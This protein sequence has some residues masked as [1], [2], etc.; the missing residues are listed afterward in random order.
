MADNP[1]FGVY[2]GVVVHE[3]HRPVRHS[4]RYRIFML[5]IDLDQAPTVMGRLHWLSSGRFGLLSF[6]ERDHGDGSDRPLKQQV[7]RRLADAGIEA[8]GPV[9]LLTMPRVLGFAFNPVSIYFCHRRSGR[10]AATVY[11]VS[12]TFGE[13]HSYVI[14]TDGESAQRQTADKQFYVSPFMD[15]AMTYRFVLRPPAE[16]LNLAIEVE[17]RDGSML[18]AAFTA[19]RRPMT[20]ADL[21]A[22]WAAHPLLIPMVIGGIH[23]EALK[24]FLKGMKARRRRPIH[25]HATSTGR[26]VSACPV[27]GDHSH[28]A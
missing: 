18:T 15:M 5:L 27:H 11:E 1:A 9:R 13:R 7:L 17:D 6:R 3:R 28:V 2:Q 14:A 8:G 19:R 25:Q 24:L 12:N 26:P 4:L 20:D 22:A 23:W 10:L 16:T 21:L